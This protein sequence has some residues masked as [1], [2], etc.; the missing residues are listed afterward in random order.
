MCD[1]ARCPGNL[2]NSGKSAIKTKLRWERIL[3]RCSADTYLGASPQI[4]RA[5]TCLHRQRLARLHK[6]CSL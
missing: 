3:S 4:N 5:I 2:P 6:I 1:R